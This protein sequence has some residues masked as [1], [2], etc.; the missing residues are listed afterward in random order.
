MLKK[1]LLEILACPKCKGD[2][3][4]RP[5][6]NILVCNQCRLK[7]PIKEDIPIMLIDKAE[8]F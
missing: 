8:P 4:Y 5:Q 1:E 3:D 6:E 7:Y 2:L